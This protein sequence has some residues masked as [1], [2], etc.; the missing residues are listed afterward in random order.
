M[1]QMT[2]IQSAGGKLTV[3]HEENPFTFSISFALTYRLKI[4]FFLKKIHA[5]AGKYWLSLY[6]IH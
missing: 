4:V 5:L 1:S 6:K 3:T 2:E